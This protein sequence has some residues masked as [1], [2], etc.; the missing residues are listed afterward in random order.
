MTRSASKPDSNPPSEDSGKSPD[1]VGKSKA[2][3]RGPEAETQAIPGPLTGGRS[4]A[5]DAPVAGKEERV[6]S[7]DRDSSGDQRTKGRPL[8]ETLAQDSAASAGH[9]SVGEWSLE[10]ATSELGRY[11]IESLLGRGGMRAV[12]LA[13]DTQLDRKVALKVPKF[14]SNANPLLVEHFYREARSAANLSHPNLCPVFDV[15]EVDGTHYIAMALIKGQPL[16]SYVNEEKTLPERSVAGIVRKVA[17]AMQEAHR[18]GIIHRDLKPANIMIDH[19]KEPIVMDFGL[20][21]PEDLGDDSRLIQDG[22][23]LGSPAYVSPEQLRG[24]QDAIGPCSDI[25]SLGVVLYELLSG[26]L[27]FGGTGS[28]VAMIGQ[29]LTETAPALET[30][31]ADLDPQL[32]KVCS[33]AMEKRVE[34][35]YPSMD[36]LASD[37]GRFLQ[38]RSD[39]KASAQ[40][41]KALKADVTRIQ[42]RARQTRQ[43]TL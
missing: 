36:E 4:E 28:T 33:K 40:A 38:G 1:A 18:S 34:D 29:I 17:L 24:H 25:Y 9:F 15:G 20:A 5:D 37:L 32:V 30:L 35:R 6:V 16:S 8:D 21:C 14:E 27:P 22:A 7:T 19:R 2:V 10:A 13:H 11:R 42:L 3:T 41:T 31:R 12:Y 26:R 23:I 39:V 43:N